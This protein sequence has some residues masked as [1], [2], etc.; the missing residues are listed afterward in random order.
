MRP[1][2]PM[3]LFGKRGTRMALLAGFAM[4]FAWNGS[5][6][7]CTLLLQGELG[8]SP[9]ESGFALLPQRLPV[10]WETLSEISS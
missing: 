3:D 7:A 5:V 2:F 8:F 1:V 10:C 6:F 9:L 4:I